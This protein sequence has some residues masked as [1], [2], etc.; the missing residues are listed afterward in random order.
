MGPFEVL[1]QHKSPPKGTCSFSGP[2]S[3]FSFDQVAWRVTSAKTMGSATVNSHPARFLR[4]STRARV[5]IRKGEPVRYWIDPETRTIWKMQFSEPDAL[6]K[7]GD[8]ARWRM[9]RR[10]RSASLVLDLGVDPFQVTFIAGLIEW[11]ET[12]KARF[13][14]H[15]SDT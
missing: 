10:S 4:C 8:L 11:P 13:D 14:R 3:A 9:Q 2:G 15:E 6:S 7:N 5:E 12:S 1:D